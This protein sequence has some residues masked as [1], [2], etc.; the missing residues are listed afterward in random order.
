M[1]I[2]TGCLKK[3]YSHVNSQTIDMWVHFFETPCIQL[4]YLKLSSS[5][6]KQIALVLLGWIQSTHKNWENA[7]RKKVD[8][9]LK[10]LHFVSG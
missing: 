8:W 10:S 2:S 5:S 4:E 1:N 3:M 6:G 9:L 7:Q